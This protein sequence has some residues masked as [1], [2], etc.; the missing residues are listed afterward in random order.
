MRGGCG[1]GGAARAASAT[2]RTSAFAAEAASEHRRSE[3]FEIG[4]AR[5]L[6]HRAARAAW[7]PR[8]AAAERRCP[9][10]EANAI[11]ARSRSSARPLEL[12]E[13]AQLSA[14][15][16]SSSAASGAP[17]SCSAC[18]A[19]S[20]RCGAARRVGGQR[21]GALAGTRL[22]RRG[23][24]APAPGRPSARALRRPPRRVRAAACA[25]CQARRSGSTSG[26]VASA[27]ARCTVSPLVGRRR[28][29]DRRA[30]QRV[31]EAHPRADLEQTGRL[32]RSRRLDRDPEPVGGTPEQRWIADRLGTRPGAAAVGCRLEALDSP[33]ETLF[34]PARQR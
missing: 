1:A 32:G 16:S 12:V 31:A 14:N 21:R 7:R 4:L 17:A 28:A 33:P 9:R 3:R 25:R 11:C 23:R 18:A 34:D 13:R 22:R 29:V 26:S 19:A 15:A 27:S 20:A 5:E 8:A 24:R 2:S 6:R 10:C 30:E